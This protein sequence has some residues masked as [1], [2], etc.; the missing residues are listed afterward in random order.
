MLPVSLQKCLQDA[1]L[2]TKWKWE[3]NWYFYQ[4][5]YEAL[6]VT[7]AQE[8]SKLNLSLYEDLGIDDFEWL[9]EASICWLAVKCG[10]EKTKAYRQY[11]FKKVFSDIE[12]NL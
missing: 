5:V 1:V 2:R 4:D 9:D 11:F 3:E 10:T 6:G 7:D 12:N 8:R